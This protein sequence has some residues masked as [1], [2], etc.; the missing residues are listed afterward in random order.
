[1]VEEW[2]TEERRKNT[3]NNLPQCHFVRRESDFKDGR[4][5]EPD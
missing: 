4:P 2:L 3:Y 5:Q 1:M